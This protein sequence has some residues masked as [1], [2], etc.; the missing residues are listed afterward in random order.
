[1][2]KRTDSAFTHLSLPLQLLAG[3]AAW[4]ALPANATDL[5]TE[6]QTFIRD[7]DAAYYDIQGKE[8][9][10]KAFEA[11]RER[12]A[13]LEKEFPTRAEPPALRGWALIGQAGVQRNL[14]ALA[15][16]TEAKDKLEAAIAIDP[17]VFAGAPYPSL[18]TLYTKMPTSPFS[19]G[20]KPKGIAYFQKGLQLDPKG[21][22]PNFHYA[23]FLAENNE[24]TAALKY[25]TIASKA[26]TRKGRE[27][28]DADLQTQTKNLI[29]RCK[30][31]SR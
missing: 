25:A 4:V 26:T 9:Q 20:D 18:G 11:L 10:I 21:I 1:M 16:M 5:Q 13:K 7:C 14:S 12:A 29:A 8:A 17:N 23:T 15:L 31:R 2:N 30:E 28:A 19:F 22:E 27:K 24:C 3:V 6:S